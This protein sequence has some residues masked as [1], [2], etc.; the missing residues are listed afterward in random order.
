ML[1]RSEASSQRRQV[2]SLG[3]ACRRGDTANTV[4]LTSHNN[5]AVALEVIA[6]NYK[7]KFV[8]NSLDIYGST[9]VAHKTCEQ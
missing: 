7:W 8:S 2:Y 3:G 6:E 5:S 4:N 9:D 1:V